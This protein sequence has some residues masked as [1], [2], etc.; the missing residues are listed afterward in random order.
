M[1]RPLSPRIN[2]KLLSLF[3][4]ERRAGI[5]FFLFNGSPLEITDNA[6]AA[7]LPTIFYA[8]ISLQRKRVEK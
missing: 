5:I 4:M 1:G 6:S 2:L 7:T 3:D 8:S